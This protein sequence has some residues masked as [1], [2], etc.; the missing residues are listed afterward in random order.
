MESKGGER[1]YIVLAGT[2]PLGGQAILFGRLALLFP[3][4][5]KRHAATAMTH[6]TG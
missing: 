5:G 4:S 1:R 3:L 2:R 6:P